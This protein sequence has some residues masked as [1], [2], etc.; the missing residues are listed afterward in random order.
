MTIA[1]S[2]TLGWILSFMSTPKTCR[3]CWTHW[4]WR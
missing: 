1:T 3:M 4:A 2:V